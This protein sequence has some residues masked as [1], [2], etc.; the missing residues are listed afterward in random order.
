MTPLHKI[1][2]ILAG[3]KAVRFD[4]QDKGEILIKGRRLIDI[5]DERLNPQSDS[6]IIS[7]RHD[8]GL[9]F[10]VVADMLGAPG[11]PVGG[12][13]SIWKYFESQDVQG[14]F[15]VAID[16]PNLPRDLTDTLYIQDSS[17]IAADDTGRH[18]TYGWWRMKDL[19]K[20]FEDITAADSLSLNRLA[21][22]VGAKTITWEGDKNFLNINRK[23]DLEKL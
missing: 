22:L 2:A 23:S 8:Y 5:I 13:Y 14:F 6:L 1:V 4:G 17:V 21:D 9:G 19:S 16:G 11:G 18:P 7:G 20:V 12:I 10:P 15:T 3:G